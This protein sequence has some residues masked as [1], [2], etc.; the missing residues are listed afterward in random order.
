[1]SDHVHTPY[2]CMDNR[3]A[4]FSSFFSFFSARFKVQVGWVVPPFCVCKVHCIS[5]N[6][7]GAAGAKPKAFELAAIVGGE[8]RVTTCHIISPVWVAYL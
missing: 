4:F 3:V 6:H 5:L 7:F 8:W 2:V 1:M